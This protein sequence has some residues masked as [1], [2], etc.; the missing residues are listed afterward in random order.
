MLV[1]AVGTDNSGCSVLVVAEAQREVSGW[2]V[3]SC[4]HLG[5]DRQQ[6]EKQLESLILV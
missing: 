5:A 6:G 4:L 2:H 1:T 3:L